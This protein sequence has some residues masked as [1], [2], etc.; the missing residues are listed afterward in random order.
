MILGAIVKALKT[1]EQV[2]SLSKEMACFRKIIWKFRA[3]PSTNTKLK[4][5]DDG[6]SGSK[7]LGAAE[8]RVVK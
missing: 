6:L 2:E 3:P 4:S 1:S 7:A 8:E 5:L